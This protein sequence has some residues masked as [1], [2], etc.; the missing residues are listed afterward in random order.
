MSLSLLACSARVK[1][2]EVPPPLIE[3][4]SVFVN[5]TVTVTVRD[6]VLVSK[7][8]SLYYNAYIE[9]INNKPVLKNPEQKNT[10][11]V[12]ANVK[13]QDGKLTVDVKTKA[14][15][16]F[17]KWKETFEKEN[18]GSV[19]IKPVPYPV[20]KEVPAELS[21]KQKFYIGV[22]RAITWGA[23]GALLIFILINVMPWKK[24]L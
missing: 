17:L 16:L 15:N 4:D 23:I 14:Q 8:D 5:K 19:K 18:S 6:T 2:P 3:K 24:L 22:G 7:P 1:S 21:K 12:K 11:G 20:I 9:C 10:S 13:L